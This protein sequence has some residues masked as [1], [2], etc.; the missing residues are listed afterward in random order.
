M[1]IDIKSEIG[2]LEG[3]IL[4]T[5][6]PEV[7]NMTPKNAERALYSDILNLP[8]AQKEYAQLSEL[9]EAVTR[10][11]QVQELLESVL[12]VP[13][14]R[15]RLVLQVC[16]AEGCLDLCDDL[17]AMS[18][19][20]LARQFIQGVVLQR[21]NLT[22][23][24]SKER[25]SL[26]PLH[27]FF[28]TRD[29]AMA[30]L[31][32][33]LIGRMAKPVRSRESIIM[34][35]IFDHSPQFSVDTVN[36]A[37][38]KHPDPRATIEGGDVLVARDDILVIGSGSRT[39]SQ[40]IDFIIERLKAQKDQERHILVQELPSTPES[41]I[42]LDMVF[43]FLDEAHCMIFEPLILKTSKYQTIHIVIENGRVTRIR[44]EKNLIDALRRLKLDLV[45]ISCGGKA[46]LWVQEREQ[47]HSGAN[48]F[49]LAPGQ[50]VGYARNVHTMEEMN[51]HGFD[52]IP[53]EMIIAGDRTLAS[54][55]RCAITLDGS[56]LPRGGGGARCMTMP[57]HRQPVNW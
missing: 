22:R 25:F 48:F 3:V 50:V 1:K 47:W 20:T 42:H 45:P 44:E 41:F 11:F 4:H 54:A 6:G 18:A 5:P 26:R 39:S 40:G 37:D 46:D 32:E 19:Q 2:T 13:A 17:L 27:N 15:D 38:Q 10:T 8:V 43:T 24:L 31:D 51:N 57:I 16:E 55:G 23:F 33:V 49:A 12:S 29:A 7:E 56:E 28:F 34:E 21:D 52:I 9:L 14:V 36:P 53:A 35:A 30:I